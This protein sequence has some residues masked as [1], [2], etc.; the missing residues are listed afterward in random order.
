[1][2][3]LIAIE[4]DELMPRTDHQATEY[5]RRQLVNAVEEGGGQ[6][7]ALSAA[8]GL[9]WT[10]VGDVT[11]LV[12]VLDQ[13]PQISW[14]QLPW[15]GVEHVARSELLSRPVTFTCAKEIFAEQV[16]EHALVLTLAC[17]RH[18]VAQ[19]RTKSWLEIDP[20]S[21]FRRRVTILGAGGTAM[22]LL[23]LLQPFNCYV[24]VLR[25][26]SEQ[27]PGANETLTLDHLH[28][29]LPDTDVL[30]LALALTPQTA[31]IIGAR[32]L[33]LLPAHAVV[34]NIARGAHI[35]TDALTTAVRD[36]KIAAAGLD[37]TEPEPLPAEHPLW[38]LDNVLIT[39]HCADSIE[40]VTTQLCQLV[41]ENV[42]RFSRGKPLT[43]IVDP[44][45][46]Y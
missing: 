17:L 15:A 39:S 37:V 32:E 38:Q 30:V 14:V 29:V 24:R 22:T 44:V 11:P 27:V 46:G 3:A 23:S 7:V 21:L 42:Q 43:G 2:T 9:I 34:V 13:N 31:A 28:E 16:G 25:R 4:S 33:D 8:D 1:M 35:D 40:F 6:V 45:A 41:R 18:V 10:S 12:T 19:A 26:Q 5:R 20:E 36:K